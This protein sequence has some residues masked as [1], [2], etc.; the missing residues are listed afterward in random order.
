MASIYKK[1]VFVRDPA[2]GERV[3]GK[4]KK[5]WGRFRD[6]DDREK[7]VPL[8]VDRAAA[9]AMLAEYV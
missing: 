2:T 6:V 8:T 4:S 5:W 1:P 7:R 3:K 9:Q